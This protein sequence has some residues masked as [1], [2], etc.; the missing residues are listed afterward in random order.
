MV[1]LEWCFKQNK[2]IRLIEPSLEI[3]KKYLLDAKIDLGLVDKKEPKWNII[4]EYYVCYIKRTYAVLWNLPSCSGKRF[5]YC[6]PT[7][8]AHKHALYSL[9]VKCGVKCE[10]HDCTLK[11]MNVFNFEKEMQNKLIDLKKERVGVQYYLD[12]SKRDYFDFAKDFFGVCEIKFMELNDFE[13]EKIRKEIKE[14]IG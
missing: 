1:N 7:E 3:A 11:L 14:M 10:I 12:N 5:L 2:G 6:N 13:I 9:L 8:I 4:K